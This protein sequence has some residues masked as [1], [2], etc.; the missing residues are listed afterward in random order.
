MKK[1]LHTIGIL[2]LLVFSFLILTGCGEQT[3]HDA[4]VGDVQE[5]KGATFVSGITY[6]MIVD[7]A[8]TQVDLGEKVVLNEAAL[9]WKLYRDNRL[10]EEIPTKIATSQNGTL[11]E[12]SN[13]FYLVIY[14]EGGRTKTYILDIVP[15]AEVPIEYYVGETLVHCDTA[16]LGQTYTVTFVPTLAGYT[17]SGWDGQSTFLVMEKTTLYAIFTPNTYAVTY[18]TNGGEPLGQVD[19]V[20]YDAPFT[21]PIPVREGYYF[22]GWHVGET[23]VTDGQGKGLDTWQ[24]PQDTTLTAKWADSAYTIVTNTQPQAGGQVTGAGTYASDTSVQLT[25]TPTPGYTFLGWYDEGN[26]RLSSDLEYTHFLDRDITLTAKWQ[27]ISYTLHYVV[28]GEEV[29]TDTYTVETPILNLYEYK[30]Q[31]VFAGWYDTPLFGMTDTAYTSTQGLY[32]ESGTHVYLYGGTHSGT[33]GLVIAY[34]NHRYEVRGYTGE[35]VEVVIPARFNGQ[36][37]SAI[38]TGAF[39]GKKTVTSVVIPEGITTIEGSAF[40]NCTALTELHIPKS[41]TRI[42]GGAFTGCTSISK[43]YIEDLAVWCGVYLSNAT[44]NPLGRGATLYLAGEAVTNLIIPESVTEIGKYAFYGCGSIT[45]VTIHGEVGA[46]GKHAFGKCAN[47]ATITC[48]RTEPGEAWDGEWLGDSTAT[49]EWKTE[50]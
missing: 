10:T 28:N 46:I 48:D 43:V 4:P 3:G 1:A 32:A 22:M 40:M 8:T 12:G 47:L 21:L 33:P 24:R 5:I 7:P 38:F 11:E 30:T 6:R 35:E 17:F 25:A 39:F 9:S 23:P 34:T 26:N 15:A 49:V 42:D 50:E 19:S 18:D 16:L 45:Q 37:V 27:V 20:V 14:S 31:E 2:F 41:V 36:A 44:S 13:L 29:E